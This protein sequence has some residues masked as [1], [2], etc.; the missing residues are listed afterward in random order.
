M[1]RLLRFLFILGAVYIFGIL[2]ER[3]L[4]S[5]RCATAGGVALEGVC[6][7]GPNWGKTDE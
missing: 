5:R 7:P 4:A 1:G 3:D 2:T 6:I